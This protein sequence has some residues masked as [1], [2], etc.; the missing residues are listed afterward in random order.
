PGQMLGEG[1]RLI[2]LHEPSQALQV[3]SRKRAGCSDRQTDAV[4][5][6]RV[7]LAYPLEEMMRR[8]ACAHVV[9]GMNLEPADGGQAVEN[10]PVM[11]RL[12][13]HAGT[14]RNGRRDT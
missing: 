11:L 4:K 5:R 7:P 1:A 14:R 2:A 10:V 9:L 12:Q 8:T 13:P 6:E 3:H